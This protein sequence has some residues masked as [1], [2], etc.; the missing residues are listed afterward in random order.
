[1]A[2][3]AQNLRN[4]PPLPANHHLNHFRPVNSA[5]VPSQAPSYVTALSRAPSHVTA[6]SQSA[7]SN[8]T[9]RSSTAQSELTIRSTTSGVRT[10]G[11]ASRSTTSALSAL[12]GQA[13]ACL[14]DIL[15]DNF[16]ENH[17]AFLRPHQT[18]PTRRVDEDSLAGWHREIKLTAM[19]RMAHR[20]SDGRHPVRANDVVAFTHDSEFQPYVFDMMNAVDQAREALRAVA[21]TNMTGDG[22]INN[23]R[24]APWASHD[25]TAADTYT[26]VRIPNYAAG[27]NTLPAGDPHADMRP[28]VASVRVGVRYRV[29]P[30]RPTPDE[31]LNGL[32]VMHLHANA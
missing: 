10:D 18:D 30:D 14:D 2:L 5:P 20:N 6:L 15:H 25:H 3:N 16:A 17:V 12:G 9:A 29:G 19:N 11:G 4:L 24:G 22:R 27:V 8:A 1:M 31:F 26:I 21:H 13:M 23:A 28:W 32:R 7:V